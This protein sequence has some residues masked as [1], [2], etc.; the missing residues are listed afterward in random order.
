MAFGAAIQ[1][2]FGGDTAGLQKAKDEAVLLVQDLDARFAE[3]GAVMAEGPK[4][5]AAESAKAFEEIWA[6]EGQLVQLRA[7]EWQKEEER[8]RKKA[9]D[10]AAVFAAAFAEEQALAEK[11]QRSVDEI[12]EAEARLAG[13]KSKAAF[14]ELSTDGKIWAVRRDLVELVKQGALLEQGSAEKAK[15]ALTF[16][17]KKLQL[18]NLLQQAAKEEAD[19][20]AR[21]PPALDQANQKMSLLEKGWN[22]LVKGFTLPN[23]GTT[24]ATA[25]GINLQEMSQQVARFITGVSKTEE[26]ALK[27]LEQVS[28]LVADRQ[29]E[30]MRKVLSEEKTYRLAIMERD[31]LEK[32]IADRV[33]VTAADAAARKQDELNLQVKIGEILTY[34]LKL[35]EARTREHGTYVK[36]RRDD[37][38]SAVQARISELDGQQKIKE[39]KKEIQFIETS[40][41]SGILDKNYAEQQGVNLQKLRNDLVAEERRQKK[42]MASAM[43]LDRAQSLEFLALE[44]KGVSGLTIAERARYDMLKLI[45]TQK[46]VNAEIDI[47]LARG[48]GNL[49]AADKKRLAELVLQNG[50][51]DKQIEAKKSLIMGANA[52]AVAEAAVTDQLKEQKRIY[53]SGLSIRRGRED[54]DLSDRELAE[55]IRNLKKNLAEL[56][57]SDPTGRYAWMGNLDRQQLDNAQFEERRRANFRDEY[58]RSGDDALLRYSAFDEQTLRNYIRPEDEARAQRDSDAITSINRK[59]GKII[60]D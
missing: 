29:I 37:A 7:A 52:H 16:E 19:Q 55:K 17:E 44:Q 23:I 34:Q 1:A 39:L 45:T 30:N 36:Q 42:E 50:V 41:R 26:E 28:T 11:K 51:L 6:D 20:A 54:K 47:I 22:N 9:A 35:E 15:T 53:E 10:S 57:L 4:K 14:D 43:A 31:A 25:L 38:E 46:G 2:S 58:Q 32:K 24:L 5:L 60:P 12:R 56:A 21:L 40:L 59:L 18:R 49:T 3:S 27:Q 13:F 8:T 48:V 33:V